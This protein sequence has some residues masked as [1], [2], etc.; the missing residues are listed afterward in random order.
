MSIA[1]PKT[2]K[3]IMSYYDY[4]Q[5]I[6]EEGRWAKRLRP[7]TDWDAC[8]FFVGVMLDQRSPAERAWAA[9]N[10]FVEKRDKRWTPTTFWIHISKMSLSEVNDY[11]QFKP[12]GDYTGFYA[13]QNCYKFNGKG[14]QKGWLRQNAKKIVNTY[15]GRVESI[16]TDDL[17]VDNAEKILEIHSR[18]KEFQG[19]GSNL[20]NMAVFALVRDRGY[21]G[22]IQSKKLLKIKFDVHVNRVIT[23]AIISGN[24]QL[25]DAENYVEKLNGELDSPADFDL[26]LYKIGQDYCQY[27]NCKE[28]PIYNYCNTYK[29]NVED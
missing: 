28:C 11:C 13:G 2:I 9:S 24:P 6:G 26:A 4:L 14:S 22:G 25:G 29:N 23:K 27:D 1:P 21:A 18:F 3:A 19:I 12:G 10:E 20:A 8:K 15:D 7:L 5:E 16:W 17:P